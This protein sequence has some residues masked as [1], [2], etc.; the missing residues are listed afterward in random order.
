MTSVY[1]QTDSPEPD[2]WYCPK[3][4][5]ENG[6]CVSCGQFWAGVESFDFNNPAGL[7]DNCRDQWEADTGVFE[8]EDHPDDCDCED[9]TEV[10]IETAI[11]LDMGLLP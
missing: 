11:K 1:E 2:Y 5:H 9:C 3:H 6:F 10:A 4:A 8:F 7:C